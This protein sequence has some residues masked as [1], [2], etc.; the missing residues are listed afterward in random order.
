MSKQILSAFADVRKKTIIHDGKL[1]E[2]RQDAEPILELVKMRSQLPDDKD[3]KFLGEVPLA[4]FG[5]AL[6][7]G[8]ADDDKAWRKWFALNP[9]FSSKWHRGERG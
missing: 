4:T 2:T 7:D 8:W 9:R 1:M 5:E 6:R 3:F